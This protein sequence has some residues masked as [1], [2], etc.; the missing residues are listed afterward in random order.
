MKTKMSASHGAKVSIPK[1][2]GAKKHKAKASA[3]HFRMRH[4]SPMGHSSFGTPPGESGGPAFPSSV[5]A[6]SG[7]PAAAFGP[8]GGDMGP[9][10]AAPPAPGG[11]PMPGM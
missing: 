9:G 8:P 4:L 1:A 7:G 3:P 11:P 5:P 6:G 2:P 10:G